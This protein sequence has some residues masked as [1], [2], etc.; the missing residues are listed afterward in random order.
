MNSENVPEFQQAL[1]RLK[2]RA[3]EIVSGEP[4]C[5]WLPLMRNAAS[6]FS[7]DLDVRDYDLRQFFAAAVAKIAPEGVGK[8]T[9]DKLD[10]TPI[11]WAW[12]GLIMKARMNMLIAQPKV[13]KTALL[14]EM[15]GKWKEGAQDFLGHDFIGDCPPV[16]I[17][18]TDQS[19]ADWGTMLSAVGLIQ[20]D[21]TIL[22]P[23]KRIWTAADP[24]HFN[25]KGFEALSA[26]LE[27]HDSPLLIVDS[28]HSCVS[29]LGQEDSGSTYANPLAALLTVTAKARATTCVIHHA[30]KGVGANI[31]TSSRGTTALTAIPSQLIHMS[32]LQSENKR[33]KRITMKTQGRSGTPVNLLIER[34]DDGWVSHGDGESVEEAERLQLV[35]NE[36]S[37]RQADFFDYIEMRWQ[38]GSFAVSASELGQNF[39]L[40]TNKVSRYVKQLVTK[41]LISPCGQTEP[42][43]DGGRPSTLYRPSADTGLETCETLETPALTHEIES[44]SPLSPYKL[45]PAESGLSP[46]TPVER[47]MADGTWQSGWLIKDASKPH[48]VAIEKV[49]NPMYVIRNCR[50][51]IDLRRSDNLFGTADTEEE[52]E[53]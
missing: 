19:E 34:T 43:L 30:N 46:S 36:L 26:E 18:G 2:A 12:S 14:L 28:Y 27:K 8:S 24:L 50:W 3:E 37:G 1:V 33:D 52:M 13:G 10:L 21:G 4:E 25:E 22:A 29:P 53:F 41:G 7:V 35:A 5:D 40:T 17:V 20:D 31:V 45:N 47:L 51:G 38:L 16:V 23:I 6:Y 48:A 9:G 44:F 32:F 11:P 42:G 49:G 15:I 39:N